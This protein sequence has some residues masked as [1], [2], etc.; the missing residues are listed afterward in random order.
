MANGLS[1]LE[2]IISERTRF[3][4]LLEIYQILL[5]DHQRAVCTAMI[6]DDVSVA[7]LASD[8][9]VSRQGIYDLLRRTK[10]YLETV[11]ASLH[12]RQWMS[13]R[14]VLTGAIQRYRSDLPD[15]FLKE[16]SALPLLLG[17]DD[18]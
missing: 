13:D 2:M 8:L 17:E 5:T 3:M 10:R 16:I 15:G 7:E 12:L 11:D 1:D 4:E 18:V 14:D 9:G 6:A